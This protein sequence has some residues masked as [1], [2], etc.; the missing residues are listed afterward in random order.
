[1]KLQ[2]VSYGFLIAFL[3]VALLL[4]WFPSAIDT[5]TMVVLLGLGL[6]VGGIMSVRS[7]AIG[8]VTIAVTI[9]AV[10]GIQTA[11]RA[12]DTLKPSAILEFADTERHTFVGQ[13]D[14]LPDRRPTHTRYVV[15]VEK[16]D[17]Q[18]TDGRILIYD[19]QGWP[20]FNY[21][22]RITISGKMRAPEVLD[23]FDYPA[24]LKTQ[25]IDAL[26]SF[27]TVEK[28][29][30]TPL[31]FTQKF[32]STLFRSRE[33][34]ENR[35]QLLLTEPHASLLI[36]FITG[37]RSGLSEKVNQEFRVTGTSHIVA[38][39]GYN[40][41]LV[42]A[43]LSSLLFWLPIKRRFLPLSIALILYMLLTGAGAPVV[44]ASVMGFLGLL[45]LQAERQATPRLSLLWVA[46]VMTLLDPI[47]LWYD[48]GFQLSFLAVLGITELTPLLNKYLK[49]VPKTLGIR[50]SLIATIAAQI[51]TLPVSALTF[52]QFSFISPI[53]N[54]LIA[55]LIPLSMATGALAALVSLLSFPLGLI[56]AYI[57]WACLQWILFAVHLTAIIPYANITW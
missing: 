12:E 5:K 27:A 16:I 34:I 17:E 47:D 3:T 41:T 53:T 43:I 15:N 45:A 33:A 6:I 52:K 49:S 9:G 10:L 1:M 20:Q 11:S 54:L 24:F 46:F 25:K 51:A 35:I 57:S 40:V 30:T 22:D 31:T 23:D 44:R 55:P 37:S 39:S 4:R 38:V 8:L 48:P 19:G 36:G 13:I 7:R 26:M 2:R 14:T 18:P 50:E 56:I 29:E 28:A 21:G 42:L 32:F